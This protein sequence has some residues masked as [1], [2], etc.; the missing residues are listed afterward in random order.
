MTMGQS[1][2]QPHRNAFAKLKALLSKS[3][4]RTI[5]GLWDTIG[6]IIDLLPPAECI[7]YF[8]TSGYD[9]T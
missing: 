3:A 7:N 4:E 5:G 6:R 9:A 2:L 8:S 1:R